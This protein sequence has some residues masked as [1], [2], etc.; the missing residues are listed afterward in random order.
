MPRFVLLLHDWPEPHLDLFLES[1][2]ELLAWR[3]PVS[4][5]PDSPSP[6]IPNAA[7]RLAYLDFEGALSGDRGTV[8]R[9]DAGVFEW[10][11]DEAARFEGAKLRGVYRWADGELRFERGGD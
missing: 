9:W 4:F 1:G 7:H 5:S 8:T 11:G 2:S 10:I 6:I 3:L